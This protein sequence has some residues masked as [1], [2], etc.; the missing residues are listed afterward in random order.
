M[1]FSS[2]SFIPLALFG[3]L[4]AWHLLDRS[5]SAR[6]GPVELIP[7]HSKFRSGFASVAPFIQPAINPDKSHPR[8]PKDD[9]SAQKKKPHL[10]H[11]DKDRLTRNGIDHKPSGLDSKSTANGGTGSAA[12]RSLPIPLSP[13]GSSKAW[14]PP[15]D[16]DQQ[17]FLSLLLS[18][19]NDADRAKFLGE[20]NQLL[21][22]QLEKTILLEGEQQFKSSQYPKA[23]AS[24]ELALQ[25]A[26]RLDDKSCMVEA[27]RQ[28]GDCYFWQ[29]R[30]RQA[31]STYQTALDLAQPLKL[32]REIALLY[33]GLGSTFHVLGKFT[34]ALD[35][36]QNSVALGKD[37]GDISTVS[38]GETG[39]GIAYLSMGDTSDALACFNRSY[40]LEK[41]MGDKEGIVRALLN[42]GN[43]FSTQGN[44]AHALECYQQGLP[45]MEKLDKVAWM[46][47]VFNN[48][49]LI[50]Q[51][52]GN[53]DLAMHYYRRSLALNQNRLHNHDG[54][55]LSLINIGVLH[56]SRGK[57][58]HAEQLM[59]KALTLSGIQNNSQ[60]Q[61]VAL[62]Q[63]GEIERVRG[64]YPS[65]LEYFQKSM[66]LASS[67]DY[68]PLSL[69]LLSS[70]AQ[71]NYSM[72]NYIRA[73]ETAGK[74]IQLGKEMGAPEKLWGA[75]L[76]TGQSHLALRQTAEAR[77]AFTES[78]GIIEQLR[79]RIA[80][81]EQ[82][83]QR[84]FENKTLP[85]LAL[86]DLEVQ[87]KRPWEALNVAEK[88]KGRVLVEVLQGGH[89]TIGKALNKEEKEQE[90]KI[91]EEIGT[92][93]RQL[94]YEELQPQPSG[95][96][97]L[98]LSARLQTARLKREDFLTRLYALHP[99]LQSQ[100]AHFPTFTISSVEKMLPDHRTALLEYAVLEGK[101]ILF[102]ATKDK[103]AASSQA[104]INL[105]VYELP[106]SSQSLSR[107]VLQF[108]K[109]LANCESGYQP[110]AKELY[111]LLLKPAE[112]QLQGRSTLC[113]I[114][115]G[116][117]WKL[118]F[119]ALQ[120]SGNSFLLNHYAIFTAPSLTALE[121]MM[122]TSRPPDNQPTL[123]AYGNP[124][125]LPAGFPLSPAP[126]TRGILANLADA[127]DEVN[128]LRRLYGYDRSLIHIRAGASEKSAQAEMANYRI[129]HFATHGILDD[130]D[131]M[132]SYLSL[133][134]RSH[135]RNEDG[136]LEANEIMGMDLKADLAIL[137]ACQS[138]SGRVGAGEGLIGMSWAFFVAGCPTT[139]VSQ[140]NVDSGSSRQLMVDFH[141]S[142][143]R[144]SSSGLPPPTTALALRQAALRLQQSSLFRHPF[145]WAPFVV[146]GKNSTLF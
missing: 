136:R 16:K 66:N 80:G 128:T 10:R 130:Q 144:Q 41:E 104:A 126:S 135:S 63:I 112:R 102:V 76:T 78:I 91:D 38:G 86:L 83:R 96:R 140:W 115:D 125:G 111:R 92:L 52:Q 118:P 116:I 43:V 17:A 71:T 129:L 42:I 28:L 137:S 36:Y 120:T 54:I 37:L 46:V 98:A 139:V 72:G 69:R 23:Q 138:A 39:R 7:A 77:Q 45:L 32:Q 70:M 21:T 59:R 107:R 117:L 8:L 132:F 81:D 22:P 61:A 62:H 9:A 58:D 142:L 35:Y 134:P 113:L 74:A 5:F 27:L 6:E 122:Q 31:G 109:K 145:Y 51:L 14:L 25:I 13:G 95:S 124:A 15:R 2:T 56:F 82:A 93:Q 47:R 11:D 29:G 67:L 50:Y 33:K 119:Q 57:L 141:R 44:Y 110:L 20:H 26:Q 65:A 18:A 108:Q 101:S 133:T 97:S 146:V 121:A 24:F 4:C 90:K 143:L 89:I 12:K 88:S 127:E 99:E 103:E 1:K 48:L 68:K 19:H 100:R 105:Q 64:L 131:P 87:Q 34:E 75:Y 60:R 30:T 49:G 84:Y 123:L 3:S 79:T 53:L 94:Q 73:L 55:A 40:D 85:Y 114:P 106:V